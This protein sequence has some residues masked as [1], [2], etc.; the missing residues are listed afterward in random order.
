MQGMKTL[1]IVRE[2][3]IALLSPATFVISPSWHFHAALNAIQALHSHAHHCCMTSSHTT[4]PQGTLEELTGVELIP[5][6]TH[7][8]AVLFV[9]SNY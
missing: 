3:K 7:S 9:Y 4:L 5:I 8:E 1:Q 2:R 6:N